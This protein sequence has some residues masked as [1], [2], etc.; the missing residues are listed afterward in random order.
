M[1]KK[2]L[3]A[4]PFFLLLAAYCTKFIAVGATGGYTDIKGHWAYDDI[5]R[6]SERGVLS[7]GEGRFRP[8]D[9][10]SL[11]ELATVICRVVP[12]EEKAENTFSD[13]EPGA[14]F[15]DA[16]LKC[17]SA[18]IIGG[19]CAELHPRE[20][21]TRA[22]ALIMLARAAGISPDADWSRDSL[23]GYNDA[24]R[25]TDAQAPWFCTLLRLGI[26]EGTTP[27]Q[28]D[29]CEKMTRAGAAAVLSRLEALGCISV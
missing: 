18:G 16:V 14:W 24:R 1:K 25:I 21:L 20:A 17:V 2:L 12:L 22:D 4:I 23:R 10:I 28:L 29:P 6:W 13:V 27:V 19:E 8:D 26:I 9:G 5:V 3:A 11:A 7:G 15:E